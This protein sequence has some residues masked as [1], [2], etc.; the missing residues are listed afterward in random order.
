MRIFLTQIIGREGPDVYIYKY[1]M[2]YIIRVA[3][4]KVHQKNI[5]FRV[6][7]FKNHFII[8]SSDLD[9]LRYI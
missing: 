4:T 8:L 9:A 2:D 5:S 1:V 6:C 7:R 3:K